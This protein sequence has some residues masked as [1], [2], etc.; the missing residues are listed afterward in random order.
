MMVTSD[1]ETD[2]QGFL[3]LSAESGEP[4]RLAMQQLMLTGR[5]LPVGARLLARH[6]FVS[7]EKKP[8]EV[9]YSFQLP[10]DAALRR[11]QVTGSGFSVRSEL[12]PVK[13]AEQVY[14]EGLADGHLAVMARS[15]RDGIVNLAVG[16]LKPN[17]PVTVW[18]EMLAGVDAR[19]DSC[20]FRFPFTLA[21]S[22]HPRARTI[23]LDGDTGEMELPAGEFD[24]VLLPPFRRNEKG[25]HEIGFDLF[26]DSGDSVLDVAS[27]SHSIRARST[28]TGGRVSLAPANEA[29]NRDLVLDVHMSANAPSVY[30]G[31]GQDGKNH[32]A[33]SIPSAVFGEPK[34]E[35]RRVVFLLDRSG[36]MS[37]IPIQQARGA[38]TACLATLSEQDQF[39]I[40]AFDNRIESFET[41]LQAAT[42]GNRRR[43]S[44][45]LDSIDA[46]GGTE[47]S[48]GIEAA[49]SVAGGCA[50]IFVLTD[51]QVFGTEDILP[52]ARA[53]GLRL[54]CLGIGSASQDRFLTL[55]ARETGGVSRFVT[56]RERVD[57]T[58][59]DLF[60][61]VSSPVASE[62][63]ASLDSVPNA[64]IE[65]DIP[66]YVFA[67]NRLQVYGECGS[68][69]G[70]RLILNWKDSGGPRELVAP[71]T[72][73]AMASGE[74]L[75]LL[76]GARLITD[77]ESR[78]AGSEHDSA[79]ERR[80]QKRQN[81]SLAKLS[82]QYGLASRAMS[83]V[84]VV[85]RESDRPGE[86]PLTRVV[87]VAMPQDEE[88]GGVFAWQ[89]TASMIP[90]CAEVKR[91]VSDTR[92]CRLREVSEEETIQCAALLDMDS[93]DHED[94]LV[95][96]ASMLE[97]D[98]GMPGE[99]LERRLLLT[100][101]TILA[102]ASAGHTDTA[103]PFRRHVKRMLKF[104]KDELPGP[105]AP[106]AR[107]VVDRILRGTVGP[108]IVDDAVIGVV[109]E[110]TRGGG[111]SAADMLRHLQSCTA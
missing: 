19:D 83:L 30:R 77:L 20:R 47:L 71:L 40:V 33:A 102:F 68:E 106:G 21:P 4:V 53:Q 8:L 95:D 73:T 85:E 90:V 50:D 91:H 38:L 22:Y 58:A 57:L 23:S 87:P 82:R 13:E 64:V 55:L 89:S 5:V 99:D 39:G 60:A 105:L 67:G 74:T 10:R 26:V 45:F 59:L 72:A 88:F 3:L 6:T 93:G 51:G 36:S 110:A 2:S 34:A 41:K 28:S 7:S 11:F 42:T 66:A 86:P 46:R 109:S 80:S 108:E 65:P 16:N 48:A 84:A 27:P 78:V 98:G 56:P 63:T 111:L 92:L 107:T 43:A 52:V 101:L 54:H 32:L 76:R 69:T 14:E 9:V 104:L 79:V 94:R 17:D 25:L 97:P 31:Q 61:S 37:G 96:I 81:S 62:L 70:G 12:R 15:H 49:A 1:I 100:A 75:R 24:D 18:L 44:R 35:A 29:P 103:G